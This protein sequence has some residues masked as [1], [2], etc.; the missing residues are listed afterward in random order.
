MGCSP[1]YATTGT[2]PLIPLNITKAMYLQPPPDSI[3][4]ITDLIAH[5]VITLQKCN[6]DLADLHS[7]IYQARVKAVIAFEKKHFHTICDF[8]FK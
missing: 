4:S 8:D 1:Y 2:H 6:S 7:I 3:L 5:Y